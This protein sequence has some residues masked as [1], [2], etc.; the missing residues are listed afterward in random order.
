MQLETTT[1]LL[2]MLCAFLAGLLGSAVFW[3]IMHLIRKRKTTKLP[4]AGTRQSAANWKK[5]S[6]DE[7]LYNGR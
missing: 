2:I 6:R 7:Q 4:D 5:I 3:L 1:F